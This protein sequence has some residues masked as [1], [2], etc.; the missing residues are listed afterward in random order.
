[1]T[2]FEY[3]CMAMNLRYELPVA[4]H[5]TVLALGESVV[6]RLVKFKS[7]LGKEL[8]EVD[9]IIAKAT[10]LETNTG[11]YSGPEDKAG[12]KVDELEV[13]TDIADLMVDLQVY[14]VSEMLKY[15]IP[16]VSIQ[17]IVMDSND[18]K[19]DANGQPIKDEEGKF[20]KGPNYW[21]PEPIIR[22]ILKERRVLAGIPTDK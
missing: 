16:L 9:E 6:S 8:A 20:Q 15:G 4:E 1:M 7:I 21:K 11:Y 3:R 22:R 17:N 14:C 19:L 18:S 5:P 12:H 2:D 13:L 10:A